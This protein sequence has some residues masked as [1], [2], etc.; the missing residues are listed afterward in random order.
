MGNSSLIQKAVFLDRD[1]VINKAIV[2]NKNPYPPQSLQEFFIVEDAHELLTGLKEA[3]FLLVVVTNQPDVARGQ[4]KRSVVEK[5][6][7]LLAE[8]LPIDDI[9]VCWEGWDGMCNCRK[10]KPGLLVDAAKKHRINMEKSFIIGDRWRD[11]SAGKAA[12]CRTVFIDYEYDEVLR[13]KPDCTVTNLR[14]AVR[15]IVKQ[16]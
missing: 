10:P 13:D 4:Q 14:D 6:N 15:W 2:K 16:S 11:I 1:G 9:Y 5:M 8:K 7:K 3:G 12:S